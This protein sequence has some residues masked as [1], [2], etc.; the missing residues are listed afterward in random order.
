MANN[1]GVNDLEPIVLMLEKLNKKELAL[2]ILSTFSKISKSY[3]EFDNIS[4]CYFK[5]KIYETAIENSLKTLMLAPD[6]ERMFAARENLINVYQH[7]NYPEKALRY[8]IQNELVIP[9]NVDT[10]L[11][12][13][14]SL[15]LLTRRD[16]AEEILHELLNTENLSPEI[17]NKIKFNLGTYYLYK[18]KF[19]EGLRLFLEEGAKMKI[20]NTESIFARNNNLSLETFSNKIKA[21]SFKKWDGIPRPG[22]SI[23]VHAEAG[24]GDEII[25]VRFMKHL[26]D[27]GMIPYWYNSYPERSDILDV[28]KRQGF[29]VIKQLSEIPSTDEIYYAQSMHLPINLNLEYEDLWHGPYLVA[30]PIYIENWSHL[31]N[32]SKLKIGIRWQG[33]PF[34]DNDLHRSVELK[35]IYESVKHL[36]ADFYSLQK[37]NGLEELADFPGIIDL[38]SDLNSWE[39]TLAVIEHLD[40]VITTCT[41]I[42]H[43]SAATGKKTYIFVP[44]S[45]YYVWSHSTKQSPWYGDNVTLLRQ[46][47]PRTWAEPLLELKSLI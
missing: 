33:N 32:T 34:Y 7:A 11:A 43:A 26:I 18:D 23:I 16:E 37:D 36:D 38:S 40:F 9:N 19:Q 27:L 46:Q 42:A 15:Y 2:E 3:N 17:E 12:K 1:T 29:N 28:F 31:K 10:L 44:I 30:D 8:I 13:A 47:K 4:K 14:Y 35:G 24:I 5:L 39:D 22:K 21:Q 20:W 25:N 45:A 6:S 41:S